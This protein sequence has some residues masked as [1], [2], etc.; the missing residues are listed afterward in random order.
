MHLSSVKGD[1]SLYASL[2]QCLWDSGSLLAEAHATKLFTQGCR[3]ETVPKCIKQ[4]HAQNGSLQVATLDILDEFWISCDSIN[5][6][7]HSRQMF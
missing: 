1:P 5:I 4:F 2:I 3:S 7:A 6:M